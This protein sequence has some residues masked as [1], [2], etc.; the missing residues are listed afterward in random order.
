MVA[1][2]VEFYIVCMN[3]ANSSKEIAAI[4]AAHVCNT[5]LVGSAQVNRLVGLFPQWKQ[6]SSIHEPG[7]APLKQ[8]VKIHLRRVR[9]FDLFHAPINVTQH[10]KDLR[11]FWVSKPR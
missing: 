10:T 2:G 3:K 7:I 8:F 9:L 1:D 5:N 6:L 4:N 11:H